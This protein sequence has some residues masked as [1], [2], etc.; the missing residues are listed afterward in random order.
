[1]ILG[2]EDLGAEDRNA[3]PPTRPPDLAA[4]ASSTEPSVNNPAASVTIANL[5]TLFSFF[6]LHNSQLIPKHQL[7]LLGKIGS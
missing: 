6:F 4:D 3:W 1:M 7:S 2:D 5:A